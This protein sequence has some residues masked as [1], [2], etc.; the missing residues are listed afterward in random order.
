MTRARVILTFAVLMSTLFLTFAAR[1]QSETNEQIEIISDVSEINLNAEVVTNTNVELRGYN[2]VLYADKAWVNLQTG[3]TTAE[4]R[5]RIQRD[6][7]VFVGERMQYNFK[8]K[9]MVAEQFK[10]G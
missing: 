7:Q 2:A 6:N 8:T 4:G 10:T 5:V 9:Q 1:A 3:E